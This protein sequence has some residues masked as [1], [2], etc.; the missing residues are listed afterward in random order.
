MTALLNKTICEKRLNG[1][2]SSQDIF[3]AGQPGDD[4]TPDQIEKHN[5]VQPGDVVI[6][7]GQR[8]D[9]ILLLLGGQATMTGRSGRR[10]SIDGESGDAAPVFG[11]LE[12]LAGSDFEMKLTAET[13]CDLAVI[14]KGDLLDLLARDPD[15]CLRLA[16]AAGR[17]YTLAVKAIKNH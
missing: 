13:E 5:L 6:A 8:P 17:A 11:A 3:R 9:G 7:P 16:T 4:I 2:L 10:L 15:A 1:I 12:S 14:L